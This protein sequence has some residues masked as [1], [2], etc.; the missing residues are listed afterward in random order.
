MRLFSL[1]GEIDAKAQSGQSDNWGGLITCKPQGA[2][3]CW[4]QSLITGFGGFP[5]AAE[6]NK[7]GFPVLSLSMPVLE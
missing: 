1:A 6:R 4:S 2:Y 5:K 3:G 7:S